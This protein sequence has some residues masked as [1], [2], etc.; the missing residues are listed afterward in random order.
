MDA[1]VPTG[2][3]HALTILLQIV[4]QQNCM[5]FIFLQDQQV[6]QHHAPKNGKEKTEKT[7]N[8]YK[9]TQPI[10]QIGSA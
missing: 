1:S 6:V 4:H 2:S 3:E 9:K 8:P 5:A 7:K 10:E